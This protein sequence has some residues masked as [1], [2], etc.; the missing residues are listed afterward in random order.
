MGE[1]PP[2]PG[3]LSHNHNLRTFKPQSNINLR[4][5]SLFLDKWTTIL[6]PVDISSAGERRREERRTEGEKKDEQKLQ[7]V[8]AICGNVT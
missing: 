2:P 5:W 8:A 7:H 3:K 6:S 4:N 1:V